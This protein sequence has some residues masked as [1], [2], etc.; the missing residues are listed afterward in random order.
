MEK[1]VKLSSH[2]TNYR[3]T[4]GAAQG[5][6]DHLKC[7]MLTVSVTAYWKISLF[8]HVH[9]Y[10]N[11]KKLYVV[12]TLTVSY[13]LSPRTFQIQLQIQ[14]LS[15]QQHSWWILQLRKCMKRATHQNHLPLIGSSSRNYSKEREIPLNEVQSKKIQSLKDNRNLGI[16]QI[17]KIRWSY[18]QHGH[19]EGSHCTT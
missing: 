13:Y 10:I 14:S 6:T 15:A 17:D 16:T 2:L 8:M 3:K 1:L 12:Q 5:T 7:Y 18:E 19:K 9:D 11:T 4:C